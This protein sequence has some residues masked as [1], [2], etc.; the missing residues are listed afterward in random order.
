MLGAR[1]RTI[2][3]L[4]ALSTGA[5]TGCGK[6]EPGTATATGSSSGAGGGAQGGTKVVAETFN[7]ALAGAFIPHENERRQPLAD[8]IAA[9]ESDV[10][11][12]EEAWRQSDKDLIVAAAKATFPYAVSIEHDLATPIDDPAD[13]NGKTPEPYTTPPCGTPDLV[14]KMNAAIACVAA[15]CSTIPGSEDGQTTST[16]CAAMHCT[17][18]AGALIAGDADA[19][20]CYG[21]LASSLP[22][23]TLKDIRVSCTTDVNAGLAFGGQNGLVILSK[24]PLRET[25]ARVLPG[26]WNRRV[27]LY[28]TADLPGGGSVD[29]YCNHLSPI[30]DDITLPYTGRY[31]AGQSGSQAWAAEQLLQAQKLVAFVE[32]RTGAAGKAI[33]AGD[34]NASSKYEEDGKT[35]LYAEGTLTKGLLDKELVHAV[36]AGY[37]PECTYCGSNAN[38]GDSTAHDVWIDHLYLW[39]A[40]AEGVEST[41]RTYDEDVVAVTGGKVPLSDHYGL[42]SRV[43]IPK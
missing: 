33:I 20:R 19:L 3:G 10:L 15:S 41:E 8:A 38:V 4:V 28:A 35:V 42:R 6:D 5:L 21:C 36:A 34:F 43:T 37:A 13:K 30:F 11:C 25:G 32:S 18:A 16:D 2:L 26:T 22:T 1:I 27:I 31:G 7:I 29:L 12:I 40:T 24:L 14:D 23:S 17:G 39:G 9:S